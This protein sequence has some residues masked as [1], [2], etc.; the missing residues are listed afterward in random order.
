[1]SQGLKYANG[2]IV[3][4]SKQMKSI[5]QRIKMVAKTNATVLI[6]GETGTGKE[7]VADAIHYK[8][9][10]AGNN[11]CRVNCAAIS[12]TL[13]ESEFFGHKKGAFTGAWKEKKGVFEL[14]NGGSLL[15]DEIGNLTLFGQAKLLRV[16]QER[17]LL[18]VGGTDPIQLDV[19]VI[20]TTN[21]F[22]ADAVKNG[23]FRE[24]LYYRLKVFSINLPP[25]REIK[26]DIPPMAYHFLKEYAK[27]HRKNSN[28][29]SKEAMDYLTK[30]DWPGN[31]RELKNTILQVVIA[32]DSDTI[33]LQHLPPELFSPPAGKQINEESLKLKDR[34]RLLERQLIVKALDKTNW[35]KKVACNL[36]G[37]DQR[38]LTY[39]LKKHHIIDPITRLKHRGQK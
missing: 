29:F 10:R 14:A 5:Y 31:V 39:F 19:R 25:L 16:L 33:Q 6:E 1:M 34:L 32:S 18:P 15:L 30:Y 38:N 26:E 7:L 2:F 36:L 24:D 3:G 11:F 9:K 4:Q 28:K 17:E 35:K 13:L 37:I 22:L 20:V 21:I 8:S 12:E 23:A 27:K